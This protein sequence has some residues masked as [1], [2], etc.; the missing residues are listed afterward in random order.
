ME[1]LEI[2]NKHRN[3]P[4]EA[5]KPINGGR[6]KGMSDINPMWR[7]KC[8]TESFGPVGIGWYYKTAKKWL[9]LAGDEVAAFVD[10]ELF[11]KVE[12]EWSMP[13]CGT[14]GSMFVAKEKNGPF[15]SDECYKM[16][17][18]DAISVACKQLG[19][20][21]DIYWGQDKTKYDRDDSK[22]TDTKPTQQ[23]MNVN[24]I[25]SELKRTGYGIASVEQ[26][27]AEKF[28]I[29]K[30]ENMTEEAFIY[31]KSSLATLPTKG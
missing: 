18:T 14:G 2:Y 28:K 4:Q 10:I 25:K 8:L 1:N 15:V 20:A 12:G 19:I 11:V 16:A 7:I 26:K 21:A 13:I 6:M 3:P 31:L 30:L 17:T 22:P 9:E 5:L 29:T 24:I 23:Q 27:L